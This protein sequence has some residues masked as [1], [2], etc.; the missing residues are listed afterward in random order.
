M[1]IS[2][3]FDPVLSLI[4]TFWSAE[5]ERIRVNRK[6]RAEL[7]SP[8]LHEEYCDAVRKK[9]AVFQMLSAATPLSRRG[10]IEMLSIALSEVHTHSLP[11]PEHYTPSVCHPYAIEVLHRVR[12]FLESYS[13]HE[14]LM[15]S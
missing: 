1:P 9:D 7:F 6:Q 8:P 13:G 14:P 5:D 15:D 3:E 4:E 12:D 10:A 2:D 11:T